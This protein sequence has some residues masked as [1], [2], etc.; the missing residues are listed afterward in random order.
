MVFTVYLVWFIAPPL[1]GNARTIWLFIVP[2]ERSY[3]TFSASSGEAAEAGKKGRKMFWMR[4]GEDIHR[5]YTVVYI[6]YSR[7]S[8]CSFIDYR[9]F[10]VYSTP[11]V[12]KYKGRLVINSN[13]QTILTFSAGKRVGGK[14][15]RCLESVC[16]AMKRR[17]TQYSLC[18]QRFSILRFGVCACVFVSTRLLCACKCW[19]RG[20]R[21][22]ISWL[23]IC[24][25]LV[26]SWLTIT[27]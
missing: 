3:V 2:S 9:V 21:L 27:D 12:R 23:T 13:I 19:L 17:G 4:S 24:H 10:M 1:S 14:P 15:P 18:M 5:V 25:R 16:L 6:D 26:I 8:F 7:Y 22:D 20:R 11:T